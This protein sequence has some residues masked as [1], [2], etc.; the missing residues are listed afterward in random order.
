MWYGG[1][2]FIPH[3]PSSD[4]EPRT[5]MSNFNRATT[6]EARPMFPVLRNFSWNRRV[7]QLATKCGAPPSSGWPSRDAKGTTFAPLC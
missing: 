2:L 1:L 4:S 3:R 5:P 6:T 7:L